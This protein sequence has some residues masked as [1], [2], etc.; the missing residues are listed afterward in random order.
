LRAPA[1]IGLVLAAMLGAVPAAAEDAAEIAA[2]ARYAKGVKLYAAGRYEE[3]RVEFLQAHTL[4]NRPLVTVL[5]GLTSA[6]VGRWVEAFHLLADVDDAELTPK[7]RELLESRR[8]EVQNHVGHLRLE[9][10]EGAEVT[11]DGKPSENARD[12]QD[13]TTGRHSVVVRHHDETKEMTVDVGPSATVDVKALFVATPIAPVETRPRPMV[14]RP[15]PAN[16]EANTPSV[17]SPPETTWPV[18]TFGS[19]GVAGLGTAAVFGSL[20]ANSR[21]AVDVTSQTLVRG[22]KSRAICTAQ[23]VEAPYGGICAKL[24]QSER[25]ARTHQTVFVGSVIVGASATALAVGWFFFAPKAT[26]AEV[27]ARIVPTLGGAT[28]DGRF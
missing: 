10:P 8:R 6:K 9:V 17:L 18:Y 27:S 23:P 1:I 24:E 2:K 16:G 25:L 5:L 21:L 26:K 22:G 20:A 4:T 13:V 14:V 11:I 28:I 7:Q 15:D 3:A 12:L 19:I